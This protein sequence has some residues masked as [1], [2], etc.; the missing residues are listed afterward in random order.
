[1]K[2]SKNDSVRV[3][4]GEMKIKDYS[5]PLNE[6][7]ILNVN[8]TFRLFNNDVRRMLTGKILETPVN[9]RQP[10]KNLITSLSADAQNLTAI[11]QKFSASQKQ[12]DQVVDTKRRL[13]EL[14]PSLKDNDKL[15]VRNLISDYDKY[16]ALATKGLTTTNMPK[17]KSVFNDGGYDYREKVIYL[18]ESIP[19]NESAKKIYAYHFN[20]PNPTA[21]IRFNTR[22]VDNYGDTYYIG[23]IQS[24]PGQSI[25][26]KIAQYDG[27]K[28]LVRNN[29]FKNK[30]LSAIN[31]LVKEFQIIRPIKIVQMWVNVNG[32]YCYNTSHK[33]AGADL[34][35]V[36]WV[37]QKPESGC[38]VIE[39]MESGFQNLALVESANYQYTS[40][41]HIISSLTLA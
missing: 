20:D 35:G 21:H 41:K 2:S 4:V 27:D 1:M 7:E 26:K 25:S 18:D 5:Y 9:Q 33:H 6:S 31:E 3:A 17:H 23:E 30:I 13:V 34:S 39:N 36:L 14:L 37:K 11:G 12:L 22:G 29:P 10:L 16:E 24:D 32:Q 15:I 19:G 28:P 38:F 8:K 40:N